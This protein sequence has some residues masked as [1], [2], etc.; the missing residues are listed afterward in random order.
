MELS[1]LKAL[2]ADGKIFGVRFIKRTDGT[3]RRMACRVGVV[4][5]PSPNSAERNWN[6]DDKGLLQ[7]WDCHKRDYRMVPADGIVELSVRGKRMPG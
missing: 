4:P 5:P 3:L 1:T 6:P 7:V 2:T